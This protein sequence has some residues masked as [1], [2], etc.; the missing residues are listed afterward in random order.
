MKAL[1]KSTDVANSKLIRAIANGAAASPPLAPLANAELLA[2][3][4]RIAALETVMAQETQ[5][6]EILRAE[7]QR[8][9]E[10]GRD[11]GHAAGKKEAVSR[12]DDRLKQLE[13]AFKQA[14]IEVRTAMEGVERLA[15]LIARDSLDLLLGEPDYRSEILAG[16]I[17]RQIAQT[18]ES[19]ILEIRVSAQDFE[20]PTSLDTLRTSLGGCRIAIV[21]DARIAS[22]ACTM[23][24]KLGRAEIGLDQQ[25]SAVADLLSDMA[26]GVRS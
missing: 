17:R 20:D 24:F 10:R 5:R 26:G 22:G 6:N 1:I 19:S 2:A 21:Q 18:D 11:M 7:I 3:Q 14:N 9:F 12:E 13:A 4:A 23:V 25:W 15:L 8:A 16:L